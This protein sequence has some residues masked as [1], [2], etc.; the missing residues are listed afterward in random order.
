MKLEDDRVRCVSQ[1]STYIVLIY[2]IGLDKGSEKIKECALLGLRPQSISR[3]W[4][5]TLGAADSDYH[6]ATRNITDHI[7]V[8]QR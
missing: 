1:V 3:L 2:M 4:R 8:I 6:C 7:V 5:R